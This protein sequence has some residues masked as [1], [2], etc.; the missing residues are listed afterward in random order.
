MPIDFDGTAVTGIHVSVVEAL[1]E[2]YGLEKIT[3][4]M[5]EPYQCLGKIDED[6][7]E[8]MGIDIVAANGPSTFFG[9]RNE[10]WKEWR[11]PWG[12]TVLIPGEMNTT[13]DERGD[14]YL[15]P[16]GDLQA[17]PS[18]KMPVAGYFFDT[19][20]RQDPLPDDDDELNIADNLE[21]FKP[22]H[23]R[24]VTFCEESSGG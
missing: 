4:K 21:E 17:P 13:T 15:Y 18:A 14:I 3:V 22:H 10:N 24:D 7:A 12:Q 9:F 20:V 2:R 8:V 1:R 11:A 19:I 6:L 5:H 23:R 16:E